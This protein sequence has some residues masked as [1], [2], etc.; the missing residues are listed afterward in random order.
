MRRLFS[1]IST[2]IVFGLFTTAAISQTKAPLIGLDDQIE[3]ARKLMRTE[4]RLVHATEL[5]LTP[6]ESTAFW[7]VY[8][9]YAAERQAIGNRRVQLITDYAENFDAITTEFANNALKEAIDIDSELLKVRKK[10]VNRFKRALPV[11]K[12]VRFYQVESK[13]DAIVNFQLAA[14][15]PL[16]QTDKQA[17]D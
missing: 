3:A 6:E 16:I 13:L 9:E 1:I 14:Q 2:L 5:T 12:V 17:T 15:I 8:M 11:I 10:Y 7:P 4:R